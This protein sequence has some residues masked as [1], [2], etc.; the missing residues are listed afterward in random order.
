MLH[1]KM[2][3]DKML[4][5]IMLHNASQSKKQQVP[6]NL[7]KLQFVSWFNIQVLRLPAARSKTNLYSLFN[8][9]V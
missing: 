7:E 2:L 6:R 4:Q 9:L 5:I 3:C 8:E 1:N